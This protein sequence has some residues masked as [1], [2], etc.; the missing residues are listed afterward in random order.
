MSDEPVSEQQWPRPPKQITEESGEHKAWY[1][2]AKEIKTVAELTEFV[3]E[4]REGYQHDYDTICHAIAAAGIAAMWCVNSGPQGGISG[5]QAGCIMWEMIDRWGVFDKGPKRMQCF[6][7]LIYPQM[8]HKFTR[9]S[10]QTWEMVKAEA[11][12][13]LAE[14]GLMHP[15]VRRHMQLVA[16]GHIPFGLALEPERQ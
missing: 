14:S 13:R 3:T 15:D 7:D 8:E 2:R 1:E 5:F 11:K 6:Y 16:D 12:K 4:L 9:I 10:R